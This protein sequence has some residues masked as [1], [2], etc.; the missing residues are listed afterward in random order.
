L[1]FYL[2]NAMPDVLADV[3]CEGSG[4]AVREQPRTTKKPELIRLA[5]HAGQF[6]LLHLTVHRA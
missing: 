1:S 5:L 6:M 3:S 2:G 4:R